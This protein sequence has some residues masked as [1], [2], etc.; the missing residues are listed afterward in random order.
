VVDGDEHAAKGR[1]N[2]MWVARLNEFQGGFGGL[3]VAFHYQTV[4]SQM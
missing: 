4:V 1:K 2:V 3:L